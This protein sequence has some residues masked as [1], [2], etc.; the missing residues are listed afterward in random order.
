VPV[1]AGQPL[2][3]AFASMPFR[4]LCEL[5]N[6]AGERVVK[7]QFGNELSQCIQTRGFAP[8]LY[9]ARI[10]EEDSSGNFKNRLQKIII[11]P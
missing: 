5:F 6:S 9:F 1:R 7:E 3:L 11:L 10:E 2:C 8:G 4:T